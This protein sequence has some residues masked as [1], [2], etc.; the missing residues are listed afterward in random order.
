MNNFIGD[1]P[2]DEKVNAPVNMQR[3]CRLLFCPSF[4]GTWTEQDH[5]KLANVIFFTYNIKAEYPGKDGDYSFKEEEEQ[6]DWNY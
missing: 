2:L 1:V 5:D 3:V 6:S 4:H